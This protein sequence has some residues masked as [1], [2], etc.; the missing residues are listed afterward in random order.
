M[1]DADCWNGGGSEG[2]GPERKLYYFNNS[3]QLAFQSS[4]MITGNRVGNKCTTKIVFY[5]YQN[6][7]SLKAGSLDDKLK[8]TYGAKYN[9]IM[10]ALLLDVVIVNC[11]VEK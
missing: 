9:S 4:T 5:N 6:N 8:A 11:Y 1:A 7:C 10:T 3:V 2:L